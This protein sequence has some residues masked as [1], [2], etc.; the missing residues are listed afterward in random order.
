MKCSFAEFKCVGKLLLDRR[1]ASR[2]NTHLLA[3]EY[4]M[5]YARAC[6]VIVTTQLSMRLVL[7]SARQW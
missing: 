1:Y 2:L 7:L 6:V 4:A 5:T 3:L